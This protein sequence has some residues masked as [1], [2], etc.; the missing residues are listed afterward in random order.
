MSNSG[1]FK[2][3]I[4]LAKMSGPYKKLLLPAAFF[5]IIGNL[6]S[7]GLLGFAAMAVAKIA[8][9]KTFPVGAVTAAV[10]CGL[11]RGALRY[12]EHYLGHDIAF[13]LLFDIR[14]NIFEAINR[15]APAKILDRR[16]G[17]ICSIVMADVEYIETFFAH[18]L[19]PIIIGFFVPLI[20]LISLAVIHPFFAIVILPFY[21]LMGIPIPILSFKSAESSGREYRGKLSL[22]NSKLIENLQGLRELMLM[23]QDKKVMDG[24]LDD[25]T[26]CGKSYKR[27][28]VNEGA[29]ASLV[30]IVM[31]LAAASVISVGTMLITHGTIDVGELILAIVISMSS[32]GPLISLMFLSNSLVNTAAA[33]ERIFSLIDEEPVVDNTESETIK[34]FTVK[35]PPVAENI[36]FSYPGTEKKILNN[37][38]LNL[39]PGTITAIS[40]ESGRGKSTVLYLM[41]RFF[42]PQNGRMILNEKN[43]K[44]Y[45]LDNLRS[46]ITYFTQDTTLFNISVIENIRLADD[47]ADDSRV[48]EAAKRAGIYDFIES[49]PESWQTLCGEQGGR[50]SS[51]ERQRIGLARIFLQDNDL[52]LLD[53]PVSNLDSENEQLIMNNLKQGLDGRSVVLVSHRSSVRS[54]ADKIVNI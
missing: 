38:N 53:E 28:R 6:S 16:S 11:V 2:R 3:F 14:K 50:F 30:E 7:I 54:L 20:V 47:S 35:K 5:G 45:N 19:S 23:G 48:F 26:S 32:F 9:V 17:D 44:N 1:S 24:I 12:G 43:L 33:A 39:E 27:L 49:L 46:N 21:I 13:R 42:D 18:T 8:I 34:D 51:G 29:L 40:A 36:D 22:I 25:T 31:V 52:I 15:L 10:I 37:F 41:M 4:R